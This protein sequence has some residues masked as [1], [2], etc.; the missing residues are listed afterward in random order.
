[1]AEN[2]HFSYHGN[3]LAFRPRPSQAAQNRLHS[4]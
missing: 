2:S 1:M 3:E 4:H